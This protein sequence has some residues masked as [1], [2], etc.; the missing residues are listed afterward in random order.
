MTL[1]MEIR[2]QRREAEEAREK[3][4]ILKLSDMHMS[5]EFIAEATETSPEYI[6]KVLSQRSAESNRP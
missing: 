4:T 6:E 1:A 5:I 3:K 2:R